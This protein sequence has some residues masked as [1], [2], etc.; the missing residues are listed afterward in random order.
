MTRKTTLF[1]GVLPI[2]GISSTALAEWT[3]KGEPGGSFASG[4]SDHDALNA[5]LDLNPHMIS[6]ITP[7]FP[8]N[9]RRSALPLSSVPPDPAIHHRVATHRTVGN[10]PTYWATTQ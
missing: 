3:G 6:V 2:S 9:A 7:K 8:I 1:P 10:A 4:N 5:A